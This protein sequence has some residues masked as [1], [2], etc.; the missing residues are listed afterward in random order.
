M[1][2]LGVIID[3]GLNGL[4]HISH[5]GEKMSEILNGLTIAKSRR[6][7]SGR[8]LKVLYKRAIERIL[9][10]AAPAWWTGS[11]SQITKITSVQRKVLLAVTGAFRTTS[12]IALQVAS[13]I[14]PIDLICERERVMYLVKHR[15]PFITFLGVGL[16]ILNIDLYVESWKHPSSI[17]P[18]QWDK[19]S[20]NPTPAIYTDGSKL[21][22]HVRAAF[23][24]FGNDVSGEFQYH[25]QDHCSVFQAELLAIQQALHWKKANL[26]SDTCHVYTDSMSSLKALQKLKAENNL[27]ESVRDQLDPTVQLHWVKAHVGFAGNEAADKAADSACAK[28]RVD[29]H[30][31]APFNSFRTMIRQK[32]LEAWQNKW[33]DVNEKIGRFTHRIFTKVETNRCI[34]DRYVI[35]AVINHGLCPFYLKKFNLQDCNCQCGED[36]QDGTPHFILWC[37]QVQHLRKFLAWIMSIPGLMPGMDIIQAISDSRG[38]QEIRTILS[39][40]FQRQMDLFEDNI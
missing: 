7:L 39:F 22:G 21:D 34:V 33:D 32:I 25:L 9:V 15:A 30:L 12:T 23:C 31:G 10:Y 29:I 13:G 38:I 6:G 19:N 37:P 11:V 40:V 4:A 14:E 16:D 5:V 24:V 8:V 17:P 35:Q 36:S 18:V 20:N 3:D 1:R 27:V 26:P 2:I 28:D